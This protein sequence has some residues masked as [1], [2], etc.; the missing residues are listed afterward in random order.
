LI[1]NNIGWLLLGYGHLSTI[2]VANPSGR[3]FPPAPAN[4]Q[5]GLSGNS[6]LT[7]I[8]PT[9]APH[10]GISVFYVSGPFSSALLV[11]GTPPPNAVSIGQ[12]DPHDLPVPQ[13]RPVDIY[14]AIY[15]SYRSGT[16]RTT[17]YGLIELI[18]P[19]T[20][21]PILQDATY[22]NPIDFTCP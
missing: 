4:S 17:S 2:S 15:E 9:P 3:S 18:D 6:G 21:W 12:F 19:I 5:L 8:T 14:Y 16:L 7:N 20:L 1:N 11:T 10:L 22:S 13:Q